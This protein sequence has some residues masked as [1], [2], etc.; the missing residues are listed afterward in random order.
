MRGFMYS[1]MSTA[2]PQQH[3]GI[4]LDLPP[5]RTA[6]TQPHTRALCAAINPKFRL[7]ALGTNRAT[8]HL[9]SIEDAMH[10]KYSHSFFLE[11]T[12]SLS[13]KQK[14]D[15]V[16]LCVCFGFFLF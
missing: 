5:P 15:L 7:L 4:W 11:Q 16:F 9:F 13:A 3:R 12:F 8:V 1:S 10:P 6:N 2:Y 14:D